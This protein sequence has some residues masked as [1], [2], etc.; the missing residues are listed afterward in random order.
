MT[1]HLDRWHLGGS[2]I[3]GMARSALVVVVPDAEPIVGAHRLRHDPMTSRGVPPHITILFPFRAV[4][5]AATTDRVEE[6]CREVT[7]FEATFAS[8]GRFPGEVV[9]LRPEPSARFT[10]IIR[11]FAHEFPDCPPYGGQFPDIVPHLTVGVGLDAAGADRLEA[12]LA[13]RL[14]LTTTVDRFTVLVEDAAGNW[15]DERSWL[16]PADH[17]ASEP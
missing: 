13:P 16:L 11:T 10:A 6:L 2:T 17:A 15:H 12:D 3:D 7:S 5:D 8:V 9:W 1:H 14:P 4:I